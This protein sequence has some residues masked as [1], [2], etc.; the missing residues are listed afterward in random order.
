MNESH[1]KIGVGCK[2]D[3]IVYVWYMY[4]VFFIKEY[5]LLF[6]SDSLNRRQN[7]YA[8]RV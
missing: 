4:V 5:V 2:F 6:L 1:R 7:P 8:V 3:S